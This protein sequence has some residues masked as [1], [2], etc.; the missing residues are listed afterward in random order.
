MNQKWNAFAIHAG[1]A[2]PY[3]LY[4]FILHKCCERID[5]WSGTL[6]LSLST[7][8][9]G[10]KPKRP[11]VVDDHWLAFDLVGADLRLEMIERDPMPVNIA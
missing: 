2:F 10:A 4:T 3:N 5:L 11:V 9:P 6:S 1:R 7:M 8:A